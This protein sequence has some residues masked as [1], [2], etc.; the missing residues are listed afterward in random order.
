MALLGTA[1]ILSKISLIVFSEGCYV[2]RLGN[3]I[4]SWSINRYPV[5]WYDDDDY[6]NSSTEAMIMKMAVT[7]MMMI[8]LMMTAYFNSK[9]KLI[10]F[11]NN[12]PNDVYKLTYKVKTKR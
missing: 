3:K 4:R 7:M 10:C 6:R 2:L 9:L 1:D 5:R 8:Q 12:Y 11:R